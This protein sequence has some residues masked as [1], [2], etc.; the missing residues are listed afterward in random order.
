MQ[1][2]RSVGDTVS[3]IWSGWPNIELIVDK[4]RIHRNFF[5]QLEVNN[6]IGKPKYVELN[7]SKVDS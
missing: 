6:S 5:I 4:Y 3:L 2:K 1:A 7:R